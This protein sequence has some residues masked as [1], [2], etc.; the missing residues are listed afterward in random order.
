MKPLLPLLAVIASL[1]AAAGASAADLP[2]VGDI[3]RLQGC[4]TAQAGPQHN[5]RVTLDIRGDQAQVDIATPQGLKF[6]VRGEL[7]INDQ[8][9]PRTLDWVKFTGLDDQDLPDIPAIYELVGDT[10]KVC[11]GGPNSARPKEFKPGEGILAALV[12]FERPRPKD[13]PAPPRGTPDAKST[14]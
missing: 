13:A 7:R 9:V 10:F 1:A 11:N 4:W 2:D 12:V 6:Q 14:E 3:A 5:I 8:V